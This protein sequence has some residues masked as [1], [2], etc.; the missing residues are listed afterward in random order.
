MRK[1]LKIGLIAFAVLGIG[2][3]IWLTLLYYDNDIKKVTVNDSYFTAQIISQSQKEITGGSSFD[4]ILRSYNNMMQEVGDAAYLENISANEADTCCKLLAYSY[5]PKLINYAKEY[6][7]KSEWNVSVIDTLH[8]EADK[9]IKAGILPDDSHDLPKLRDIINTVN[10]YHDAVA[11]TQVGGITTVA[12]AQNAI[13]LANSYKRPPLTNCRSLAAALDAVPEKAK[14][15]LA[16]NIAA[17]CQRHS[18]STDVLLGRIRDYEIAFGY[19]TQ[20]SQARARLEADRDSARE[21][22]VRE[23][24]NEDNTN[25][26]DPELE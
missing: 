7:K 26:D 16:N 23:K 5:A 24:I 25:Y 6:F 22:A 17:A 21:R 13:T 9:L 12:A 1:A 20:L 2:A 8:H 14:T 19:N 3:L 10:D 18:A 15:S 11:A 4:A